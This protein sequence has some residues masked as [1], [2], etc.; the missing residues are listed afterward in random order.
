[1]KQTYQNDLLAIFVLKFDF[2]GHE[3]NAAIMPV[4]D[5]AQRQ[6]GGWSECIQTRF[7]LNLLCR[8]AADFSDGS[9]R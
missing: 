1:M 8:L 4:L 6:Y 3:N 7:I 2:V 9:R 5:L